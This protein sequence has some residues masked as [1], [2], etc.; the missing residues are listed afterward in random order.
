M[1][2]QQLKAKRLGETLWT[3]QSSSGVQIAVTPKKGFSSA[4]GHFG[5]RYGSTDTDFHV[6]GKTIRVPDGSAHFL[7]HKLFEGREEKVF[8]RF[9][10]LGADFNG[11]TGFRSTTYWFVS[12]GHFEE[13]LDILLDFVQRPLITEERVEKEKGI[14]EQEVRMYEDN[15]HFRGLFLLHRALFQQHPIR[16]PPGG[17]VEAVQATTAAQLQTCWDAFYRPENLRLSLAGDLDPEKIFAYVEDRLI[18]SQ[19]QIE[20]VRELVQE[21][22]TPHQAWAEEEFPVM[23]P[24]VRIGWRDKAGCGLGRPLLERQVLTSLA[25]D[26][27]LGDAAPLHQELYE[28]EVVDETFHTGFSGDSDYSYALIGG[29]TDHPESFVEGVRSALARFLEEGPRAQD[30]ERV[31]RSA[32]GNLVSGLQTPQALASSVLSAQLMEQRPFEVLDILDSVTAGT[33]HSRAHELFQDEHSSVAVLK[34]QS[35]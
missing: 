22:S 27:A 28:K 32:W 24:Q 13:C 35:A 11:G 21:P 20:V 4:A 12:A 7:E 9:G 25:L 8:D 26:L 30:L 5:L 31:R 23:R 15:P 16:I 17:S 6:D 10:K 18:S 33:I 2:I 29:Q 19:N 34:P 1:N 3:A 14:I